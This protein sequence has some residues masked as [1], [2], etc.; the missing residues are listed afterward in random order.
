MTKEMPFVSIIICTYNG[1]KYLAQTIESALS[2][3]YP[4]FEILIVDDGSTDNTVDIVRNYQSKSNK[5]RLILQANSGLSASRSLAFSHAQGDWIAILDQDDLAYSNRIREQISVAQEYPT[6]KLIF[7]DIDYID[8]NGGRLKKH[9]Q[10]FV[11][12]FE[13]LIPKVYAANLLLKVGCYIDSEACFIK[14]ELTE[15]LGSLDSGLTYSCDYEY[16]I[17][18]G[19]ISD[20]AW[21]KLTLGAWRIHPSQATNTSKKKYIELRRVLC[22]YFLTDN[23]SYLTRVKIAINITFTFIEEAIN[24]IKYFRW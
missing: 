2:Q 19:L 5:I 4:S 14:K 13:K 20:F 23:I 12:P 7:C 16:F 17:R 22:K 3:D 18:A 15:C 8:E 21:T 11:I 1:S 24:F 6:A 9:L 10:N